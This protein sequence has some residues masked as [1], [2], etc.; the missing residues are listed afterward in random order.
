MVES[1]VAENK[2]LTQRSH[3]F[4]AALR[5]AKIDLANEVAKQQELEDVISRNKDKE[6]KSS[7]N[8]TA[9][10]QSKVRAHGCGTGHDPY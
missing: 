2:E 1:L 3:E 4:Q 9:G 8:E 7:G 5:A 6:L 10:L